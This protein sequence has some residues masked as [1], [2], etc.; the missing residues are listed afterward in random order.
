MYYSESDMR[1]L[2]DSGK[3]LGHSHQELEDLIFAASRDAKRLTADELAEQLKFLRIVKDR[4]YPAKFH[5]LEDFNRFKGV[6][7]EAVDAIGCPT[8]DIR[9]QG[10]AMRNPQAND[11]D[12][13]V[14][15]P[16]KMFDDIVRKA[17]TGKLKENKVALDLTQLDHDGLEQLLQRI[18]K[19]PAAFNG[20]RTDFEYVFERKM[21]NTERELRKKQ[22]MA[23]FPAESV[24][25]ILRKEFEHLNVENVSFQVPG[26]PFDLQ[27]YI[28]L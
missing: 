5:D 2:M 28:R 17:F 8:G 7:K 9:I 3:A 21:I 16:E 10:S 25:A 13:A 1:M 27:P 26:G 14:M 18:K 11:V 20:Q 23:V 24:L 6:L 22:V 19:N 12:I 4:G 15:I